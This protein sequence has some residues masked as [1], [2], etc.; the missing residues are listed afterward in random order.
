MIDYHHDYYRGLAKLYFVRIVDT[1]IR[2]GRLR[3]EKGIILDFGCGYQY[4]K[5][6]LNK[7]NVLGYDIIPELSDVRDYKKLKPAVI[8]CNNVLEHFPLDE[9][10]KLLHAFKKMNSSTLLI[11][12]TPTENFISRIGMLI[13][14]QKD[15]H[16]DHKSKL[17]DITALLL[18][19]CTLIR[20][21]RLYTLSEIAVWRFR[22]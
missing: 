20:R 21:R 13:T 8:V 2:L 7:S 9:I 3:Q 19:H 14:G 22:P 17:A 16:S 12:A 18:Q 15:A 4:L 5:K 11:T 1:I 10:E 6:R